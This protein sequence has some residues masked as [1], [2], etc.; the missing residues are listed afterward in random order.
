MQQNALQQATVQQGD[1]RIRLS[2]HHRASILHGHDRLGHNHQLEGCQSTNRPPT[3]AQC[4]D[5]YH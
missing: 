5:E 2:L 4:L 3:L 1:A